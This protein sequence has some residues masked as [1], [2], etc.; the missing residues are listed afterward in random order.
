[1]R[2]DFCASI[3]GRWN[4]RSG[5]CWFPGGSGGGGGGQYRSGDCRTSCHFQPPRREVVP[6]P[7]ADKCAV[8]SYFFTVDVISD[9]TMVSTIK[10]EVAAGAQGARAVIDFGK[11]EMARGLATYT[12]EDALRRELSL[13]IF[14][15]AAQ[16]LITPGWGTVKQAQQATNACA[17]YYASVGR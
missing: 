2:M 17:A 10:K 15:E 4:D 9:A 5:A 1:M 7:L 6:N 12:Y 13:R 11:V 14:L 8:E 16:E 3:G